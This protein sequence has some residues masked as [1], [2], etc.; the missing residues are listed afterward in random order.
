[1]ETSTKVLSIRV[2]KHVY[3]ML[4]ARAS[5]MKTSISEHVREILLRESRPHNREPGSS[6]IDS[7][8]L[9]AEIR[10]VKANLSISLEA[11]LIATRTLSPEEART[12]VAKHFPPDE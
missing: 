7:E 9:L 1:M 11:I 2:E 4:L 5:S 3:D 10:S 8:K 12:F 6:Q